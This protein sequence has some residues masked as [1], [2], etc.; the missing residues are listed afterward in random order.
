MYLHVE[1]RDDVLTLA[2]APYLQVVAWTGTPTV[3]HIETIDRVNRRQMRE[4]PEGAAMFHLAV[5]GRPAFSPEVVEATK[6]SLA[7]VE[8]WRTGTAN[9]VL[10]EGL[11]GVAVRSFLNTINLLTRAKRPVRTFSDLASAT[12]WMY[13]HLEGHPSRTWREGPLLEALTELVAG[14]GAPP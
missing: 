6:R 9:V 10:L 14:T 2:T 3:D 11:A 1:Y 12:R 7:R 13:E 5:R 8:A 4:L